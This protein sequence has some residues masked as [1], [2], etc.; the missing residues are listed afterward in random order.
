MSLLKYIYHSDGR[1]SWSVFFS[2]SIPSN[3]SIVQPRDRVRATYTTVS[4]NFA[5][6]PA[7][8]DHTDS[9]PDASST[10]A[11]RGSLPVFHVTAE[12]FVP[13]LLE[14]EVERIDNL[15]AQGNKEPVPASVRAE[16]LGDKSSRPQ[17]SAAWKQKNARECANCLEI[18][19]TPLSLC[20]R[21]DS[22]AWSL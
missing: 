8:L 21:S 10:G 17:V 12:S 5:L 13:S 15:H 1:P 19:E 9:P 6:E 11:A 7:F 18:K 16:V 3:L 4:N 22:R 2:V 14:G 20:S